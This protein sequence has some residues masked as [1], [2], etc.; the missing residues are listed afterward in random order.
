M[1]SIW[2]RPKNT[3]DTPPVSS[4]SV[5]S[6]L[7]LPPSGS[8]RIAWIRPCTFTC[9]R[10]RTSPIGVGAGGPDRASRCRRAA[11]RWSCPCRSRSPF[12]VAVAVRHR[13]ARAVGAARRPRS[14]PRSSKW[15]GTIVT[16]ACGSREISR[17]SDSAV[18]SCRMRCHAPLN[19]R[20]GSSTHTS[21]SPERQLVRDGL[22]RGAREA[23]VGAVDQLE[24]EV[25]EAVLA[26]LVRRARRRGARRSRSAPRAARR[27]A[28]RA[29][30]ASRGRPRGRAGRRTPSRRAA[31]AP[32]R[33]PP[34]AR[35]GRAPR[36]RVLYCL[37]RR[38]RKNTMIGT[39]T[40]MT[41]APSVNL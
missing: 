15:N 30:T 27:A 38:T 17:D 12:A 7:G 14:S 20:S 1:P 36:P 2:R 10:Q 41:H 16:L 40:T 13:S 9:W 8:T 18:W 5:H 11:C 3:T 34:S 22:D 31:C 23:A 25:R 6:R 32:A 26:P 35:R 21:E 33:R 24:P 4:T 37:A 29:R 39:K 19:L 28:A